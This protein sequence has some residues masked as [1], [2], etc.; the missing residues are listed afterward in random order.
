MRR[1]L[2]VAAGLVVTALVAAGVTLAVLRIQSRTNPQ[3]V[4][5]HNGVTLTQDSAILQA[6][7]KGRPAVVSIVTQRQPAIIRGSGYLATSDGYIITN[8]DVIADANGLTVVVPG[9]SKSHDARLVDYDCQ[10]GVAVIKV[11]QVNG[12]PTMTWPWANTV[13]SPVRWKAA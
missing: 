4:N 6:A 8:V 13:G 5:L 9:D 10:T 12:L 7:A 1:L 11:D 3:E 2:A